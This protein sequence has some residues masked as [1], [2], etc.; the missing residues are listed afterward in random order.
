MIREYGVHGL[1]HRSESEDYAKAQKLLLP[2]LFM[3][4]MCG[5]GFENPSMFGVLVV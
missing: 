1:N 5:L 4:L 2:D 3:Q